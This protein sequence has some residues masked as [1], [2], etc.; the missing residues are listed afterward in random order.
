M[1]KIPIEEK[2]RN[3]RE[4]YKDEYIFPDEQDS[5]EKI[6]YICPKH[7]KFYATYYHLMDGHICPICG[8]EKRAKSR[9]TPKEE[10]LSKMQ[11]IHNNKYEYDMSTYKSLNEKIRIICPEHGEFWQTPSAHLQ[12]QGCPKCGLKIAH[13]KQKKTLSE[14]VLEA[15][16]IHGDK[17]D[18]SF[19]NYVNA[20]TKIKI[21]CKICGNIFEQTP[22]SHLHGNGCPICG[23]NKANNSITLTKDEFIERAKKVHGDKYDYS[24]VEYINSRTPVKII[25]P[26]HGEFWQTPNAH[27]VGKG[28]QICGNGNRSSVFEKEISDFLKSNDVKVETTNREILHG[29]E[30]DILLP[31]YGVGIECDGIYWHSEK[32]KNKNYHLNKTLKCQEKGIRLIHIFEDEWESKKEVWKST[33]LNIIHK[34]QNKIYARKCK[35]KEISG[36]ESK[37][38][39]DENHLQGNCASSI[40]LG[41]FYNDILIS[42]MTFRKSRHFIGNGKH[43]W[44]LTRFCSA[45]NLE[46]VGAASKLLHYF[47]K[48]YSPK[49]IVSYADRRWSVGNLY[50]CLGFKKYNVSPPNYYY[51]INNKRKGRFSFRKSVLVKKYNCPEN[52]SEHEFCLSQHWYRIYDCGCLCYELNLIKR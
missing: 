10:V 1:N 45:K 30:I 25:C 18:Y 3:L 5:K 29:D 47:I 12:G 43:Q 4:K 28:C 49:N 48:N 52:M 36:S 24:K 27:L 13:S 14:F 20:H 16:K 9:T 17:Y 6:C 22:L 51:L 34:N 21:K 46:V 8:I 15:R 38:F 40:N 44:E 42:L 37:L 31:E 2:I 41:L 32:F 39:L 11:N 35:I 50:E 23:R 26:E 7:G 19:V 33:L